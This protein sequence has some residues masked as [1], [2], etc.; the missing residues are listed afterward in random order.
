MAMTC[1]LMLFVGKISGHPSPCCTLLYQHVQS[2]C[3]SAQ[4]EGLDVTARQDEVR[5][6]YRR[7][8][9]CPREA[10]L[11]LENDPAG[12]IL[13]IFQGTYLKTT[14]SNMVHI[15]GHQSASQKMHPRRL[16]ARRTK[17]NIQNKVTLRMF[18]F[19]ID[20]GCWV[21]ALELGLN[22]PLLIITWFPPDSPFL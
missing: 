10:F 22:A 16:K 21:V 6:A 7:Q 18:F 12:M 15:C 9:Q 1:C 20:L 8:V 5:R 2:P 4:R 11:F 14:R 17:K 13:K 19:Y 3:H